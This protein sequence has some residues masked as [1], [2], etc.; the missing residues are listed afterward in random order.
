MDL[1][2]DAANLVFDLGQKAVENVK[3][4][5]CKKACAEDCCCIF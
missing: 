5:G 1:A 4:K 3:A 2:V